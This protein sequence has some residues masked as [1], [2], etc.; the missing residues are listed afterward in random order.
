[1]LLGVVSMIVIGVKC[2]F[3]YVHFFRSTEGIPVRRMSTIWTL[4]LV[5]LDQISDIS[6]IT[7]KDISDITGKK[8]VSFAPNESILPYVYL[9]TCLGFTC[10]G[11]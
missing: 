7:G 8:G 6:D 5:P 11:T 10:E 9:F 4:N 3:P 2:L 1:M